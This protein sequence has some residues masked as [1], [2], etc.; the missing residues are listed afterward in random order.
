MDWSHEAKLALQRTDYQI[1]NEDDDMDDVSN[2]SRVKTAAEK[3][4]VCA[5]IGKLIK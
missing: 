2:S 5:Y 3:I 4:E 1:E